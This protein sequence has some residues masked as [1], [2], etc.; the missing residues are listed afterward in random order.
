[1]SNKLAKD[2]GDKSIVSFKIGGNEIKLSPQIVQEYVVG[3]NAD[4]T[5]QEYKYFVELCK[6]RGLN[7]FL[8]EAYLIKYSSNNPAQIVVGKDAIIKRA[9]MHKSFNGREQGIIIQ[10]L[11]DE[12]IEYRKGTFKLKDDKEKLVGGWAKVYRKDWDYPVEVTVA[13]DE[14]AQHKTDGTLNSSWNLKGATMVEK[15]A[16]VRALR[17]AF[18]EDLSGMYD[19]DEV[20]ESE[21]LQ[22]KEV[23]VVQPDEEEQE[24]EIITEDE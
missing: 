9:V 1:M 14:V 19:S 3:T 18:V 10:K 4:I 21:A 2:L 6:V 17:E 12:S 11:S 15:V 16:V 23:I 22:H 20:W 5:A 13:F 7:P 8:R 24:E